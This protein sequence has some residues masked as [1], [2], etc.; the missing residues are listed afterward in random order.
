[1]SK[2]MSTVHKVKN[3]P[4]LKLW[5]D[6]VNK[7]PYRQAALLPLNVDIRKGKLFRERIRSQHVKKFYHT[8]K[9][10]NCI[11]D[12]MRNQPDYFPNIDDVVDHYIKHF[13]KPD[14][15]QAP[16]D[17]NPLDIETNRPTYM[18]FT[19]PKRRDK[20]VT[21]RFS[22]D[23]QISCENDGLGPFRNVLPICTLDDGRTLL[24]LNRHRSNHPNL[25][26]N[27]HVTI[28]EKGRQNGKNVEF[29]TPIIIDPGLGNNG[30][31]LP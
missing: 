6:Y 1:M 16:G 27:L 12:Y 5:D 4:Y 22:E 3:Q 9:H 29:K 10:K 14:G 18:L 15:G 13:A 21:W 31:G 28:F 26:F 24:V 19:L 20:K 11:P 23:V 7:L 17:L 25:K 8:D 30:S 2:K